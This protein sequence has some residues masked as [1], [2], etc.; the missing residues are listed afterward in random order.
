ME[1]LEDRPD[2]GAD[3]G[4]GVALVERLAFW[5]AIALPCLHVP[6]LLVYGL[7]RASAPVLVALWAAH[8]LCLAASARYDPPDG[9]SR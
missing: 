6:A 2:L 3:P 1:R 7:D 5:S 4:A 9:R 8:A